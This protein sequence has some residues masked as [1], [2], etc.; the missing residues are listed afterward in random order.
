[1]TILLV[2]NN[3]ART[4]L[5]LLILF[6]CV[7]CDQVTKEWARTYL[8]FQ[9]PLSCCR[10][11]VRLHYVE[12]AGAFLGLGWNLPEEMRIL[13]FQIAAGIGLLTLFV[14]LLRSQ[15]QPYGFLIAWTL[16]LSGGI[17][18][19]IDRLLHHGRVIDFMNLGVGPLRTGIFN[20]A[21]VFITVGVLWLLLA[22]RQKDPSREAA[23]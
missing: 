20:V 7:G 8:A 3:T 1:M 5:M 11:V 23:T 15:N 21:D 22:L 14:V 16:I 12:N 19:V 18:N 10:D 6:S 17:G 4:L 2:R 9:P 13:V